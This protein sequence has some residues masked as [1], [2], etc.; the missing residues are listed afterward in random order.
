MT[1]DKKPIPITDIIFDNDGVNINSEHVAMQVMDDFSYK[2]VKQY[3]ASADLARGDVYKEYPGTSTDRIVLAMINKFDLPLGNIKSDYNLDDI[4]SEDLTTRLEAKIEKQK[5]FANK[6]R[7]LPAIEEEA[8]Q[9]YEQLGSTTHTYK[10]I[11]ATLYDILCEHASE[12]LADTVTADTNSAFKKELKAIPGISDALRQIDVQLG[13]IEHRAL[14]TTSPE[15]RMNISL[16][17]AVDPETGENAGL[18]ELFPDEENRRISGYGHDN[19]YVLFMKLHPE[20]NP[21]STV[22]VEDSKS[23]VEKAKAAHPDFRVIGTVA[24]DF[25][26][27]KAEQIENLKSAGADII[28]SNISD[29]PAALKWLDNGLHHENKPNFKGTVLAGTLNDSQGHKVDGKPQPYTQ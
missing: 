1:I 8:R 19:K 25:Y 20:L 3:D 2:M 22:I 17:A 29:L 24:A 7:A 10:D 27:D 28:I 16:E 15:G 5:T 4:T 11:A 14:C 6:S 13:G 21:E 9:A 26:T 12:Q 23:G 18:A